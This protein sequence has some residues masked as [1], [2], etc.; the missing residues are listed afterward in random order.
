MLRTLTACPEMEQRVRAQK[1]QWQWQRAIRFAQRDLVPLLR[2]PVPD[3]G[4]PQQS[5]AEGLAFLPRPQDRFPTAEKWFNFLAKGRE[6]RGKLALLLQDLAPELLPAL[7]EA[8]REIDEREA[9][10]AWLRACSDTDDDV[11]YKE[12]AIQCVQLD[13]PPDDPSSMVDGQHAGKDTETRLACFLQ[14]QQH[15]KTSDRRI[16][17]ILEHVLVKPTKSSS[18]KASSNDDDDVAAAAAAYI[19]CPSIGEG[20]T[21]EFDGLV[22]EQQREDPN[23]GRPRPA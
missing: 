8:T 12:A 7:H 9:T 16:M 23:C 21:S 18:H 4:A 19:T 15:R 1:L 22:V 13:L 11:P 10:L 2:R 5:L 6:Y 3:D 20:M 17:I 14:Q